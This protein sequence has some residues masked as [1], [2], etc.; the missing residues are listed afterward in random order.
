MKK[1]NNPEVL[2]AEIQVGVSITAF[3]TAVTIFF[4]GLLI[5]N[6]DKYDISIRI[7]ILFLIISTFGFL[8]S[9]L[10]YGNASGQVSR[11]KPEKFNKHMI[12][13]NSISEYI[14]VYLLILS[15]PLVINVITEDLFLR[16]A[17]LTSAFAGL[18]M[19]HVSGFS[20]M[21]RNYKKTHYL[22][23]GLIIFLEIVLFILQSIDSF[24]AMYFGIGS[25]IFVIFL[26]FFARKE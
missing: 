25:I 5:A 8:Y 24:L 17:T 16:I 20:I 10:I 6:F 7:P 19:Y 21:E 14:G 4:V 22:I 26:T 11:L 2:Q 12:L 1:E 15:M 13:G 23:L 9:T 3:M 18:I